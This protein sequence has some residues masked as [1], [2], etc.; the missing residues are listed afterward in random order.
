MLECESLD[1]SDLLGI[2]DAIM[3]DGAAG[4]LMKDSIA[5][6]EMVSLDL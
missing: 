1:W 5:D 6:G 2:D 3:V 4:G